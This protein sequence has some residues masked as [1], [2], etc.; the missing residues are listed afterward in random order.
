MSSNNI[1]IDANSNINPINDKTIMKT[2]KIMLLG[3][4]AVGKSSIMYRYTQNSFTNNT[5]G[6]AGID[7]KKKEI[8]I[9][10][11]KIKIVLYDTA[12]H[13]RFR[14]V[15][16][17]YCKGAH[18]VVLVYDLSDEKSIS[19]ISSWL[20]DIYKNVDKGVPVILVGNK[21]DIEERKITEEE[22]LELSKKYGL[23]WI[24]TSAKTGKSV[25]ETFKILIDEIL[26]KESEYI[27][28]EKD[29]KKLLTDS[30][31]QENNTTQKKHEEG[32]KCTIF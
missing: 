17:N 19:N 20:V 16:N 1:N 11:N 28:M 10:N 5:L 24:E 15:A 29:E 8:E 3:E 25:E 31:T 22:G 12:G 21:C 6:T 14:N 32:C 27:K 7:F 26:K 18:G 9:D 30:S 4:A 2:Y 13:E 23:L